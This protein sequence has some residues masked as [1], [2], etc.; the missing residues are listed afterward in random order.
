MPAIF[1]HKLLATEVIDKINNDI[2]NV[3]KSN[4]RSYLAGTLG[5]DLFYFYGFYKGL[6]LTSKANLIHRTKAYLFFDVK[7]KD[8]KELAFILGLIT[9]YTLDKNVHKYI[10]KIENEFSHVRLERELEYLLLKENKINLNEYNFY[11]HICIDTDLL[12]FL[13]EL[14]EIP[15]K[16]IKK[17]Y[18]NTKLII[19]YAY[20]QNKFIKTLVKIIMKISFTYKNNKDMLLSTDILKEDKKQLEIIL[21]LWEES[22]EE[23]IIN[24]NN[25]YAYLKEKEQL[26]ENFN[27][28]FEGEE[29]D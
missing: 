8:D 5:P 7:I 10:H 22:K 28:N 15:E 18:K 6:P 27:Y 17:A 3:I 19:K 12:P 14:F 29:D 13:Y 21:K 1:A 20:N 11:E 26:S 23:T 25:Y 9:H 24:I 4:F 2:Q 16:K